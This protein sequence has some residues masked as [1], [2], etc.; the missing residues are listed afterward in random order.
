MAKVVITGRIPAIAVEQLRAQHD[1][2]SWDE[3]VVITREELLKRVK[4][5]DAIVSL[6]TEKVDAELLVAAG[7]QLKVVSNVA[8]GYN[9]IDVPACK[10]RNVLDEYAWCAH[11]GNSRYCNGAHSDVHASLGRR[12]ARY[13]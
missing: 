2:V 12:R 13:S 4:G 1:V 3:P 5:A 9:N 10:E 6:L 11:R 7:P 8:V